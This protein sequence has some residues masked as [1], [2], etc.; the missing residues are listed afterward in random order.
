LANE[1]DVLDL[2]EVLKV[3]NPNLFAKKY[4]AGHATFIWGA[5]KDIMK[6]MLS[7]LRGQI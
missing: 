4:E 7:A 2:I 6:D 5:N 3:N 1:K